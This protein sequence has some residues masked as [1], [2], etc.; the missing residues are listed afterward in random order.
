MNERWSEQDEPFGR[1]CSRRWSGPAQARSK[2]V[3]K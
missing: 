1:R 3:R 2:S